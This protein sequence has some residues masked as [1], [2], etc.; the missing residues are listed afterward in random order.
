MENGKRYEL[1]ENGNASLPNIVHCQPFKYCGSRTPLEPYFIRGASCFYLISFEFSADYCF[2]Y[3]LNRPPSNRLYF[4]FSV[5]FFFFFLR[6]VHQESVFT[7]SLTTTIDAKPR[8]C[9]RNVRRSKSESRITYMYIGIHVCKRVIVKPYIETRSIDVV[10]LRDLSCPFSSFISRRHGSFS[11]LPLNFSF[12]PFAFGISPPVPYTCTTCAARSFWFFVVFVPRSSSFLRVH[13]CVRVY[14]TYFVA[15]SRF[16][17]RSS[18]S[19]LVAFRSL[20]KVAR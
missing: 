1:E 15:W 14:S 7:A 5:F 12:I 18:R 2:L 8:H 4:G 19:T 10:L 16:D 6:N 9:Q 17:R 3:E 11:S 20:G 13:V